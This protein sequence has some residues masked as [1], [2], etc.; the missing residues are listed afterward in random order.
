VCVGV[1]TWCL[2]SLPHM[3]EGDRA[4]LCVCVCSVVDV[5]CGLLRGALL[6]YSVWTRKTQQGLGMCLCGSGNV[7]CVLCG[8]TSSSV[9]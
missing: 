5:C 2:V 4:E 9:P 3:D 7:C 1:G 6:V 8:D